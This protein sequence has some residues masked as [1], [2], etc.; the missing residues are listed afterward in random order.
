[1]P[2]TWAAW[3]NRVFGQVEPMTPT[4]EEY[5]ALHKIQHHLDQGY[6]DRQVA[7]TW[8]QGNPGA[9]KAGVNKY[10]VRYDSCAYA[11]KVLAMI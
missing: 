7:L 2:D 10:G 8:N 4:N 5:V 1:M 11:K 3:S 6:S 9:C